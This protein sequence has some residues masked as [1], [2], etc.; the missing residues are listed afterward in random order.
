MKIKKRLDVLLVEHGYAET[1]TK[2]QAVIMSGLV[3]VDGQKADKPGV[4]YPETVALEVRTGGC[5]YVSRGG[6][7]LEKAL[8][9]FG[10]D[11]TGYVCSDSGASTGGFTDCLLQQGA[12]KVFAIDVGYGQLDWKIRSDPRV[13]V[14][15]RTNVRYVTP[16]QLG[17]PLDLSVV[18]VSFISLRIVLPV[19]K[20]FLKP[21]SGQVLCLIKPQFEAGKEKVGKKGVV[22]D[23]E[24]HKEVLDSFVEL[25]QQIGMTILGLTFSPVKGPEGNIEF[26]AHLTLEDKP[27]I[28]TDT[29]QVVAQAHETLK[30]GA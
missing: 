18:D 3:Y 29:A 17:E 2:A 21:Q 23:P 15:E 5:P 8:R 22:R 27:G 20:T 1:R 11:P 12:S 6:L 16:E 24:I 4:S 25:T 26:L 13:V 30:G 14:M 10:V 28:Q 9:D 7:K 19:I